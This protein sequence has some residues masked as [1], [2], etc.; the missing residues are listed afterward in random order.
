MTDKSK[1]ADPVIY[2]RETYECLSTS[3]SVSV[4]IALLPEEYRP[5]MAILVAELRE[6]ESR[7]EHK[8]HRDGVVRQYYTKYYSD[9]AS[10]T[11]AS[12][13]IAAD[14]LRMKRKTGK[15]SEKEAFCF[16]ILAQNEGKTLSWQ[17]IIQ[18]L[19]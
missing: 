8:R 15:L 12:R 3:Y 6:R 18:L 2:T 10:K 13:S 9:V 5:R 16:N 4:G 14:M 17:R 1:H 11:S 19:E 7:N